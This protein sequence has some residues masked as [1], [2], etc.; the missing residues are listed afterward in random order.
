MASK[1]TNVHHRGM[2]T[3]KKAVLLANGKPPLKTKLEKHLKHADFFMCADGGANTAARMGF[4]PDLIIGDLDSISRSTLRS[5]SSVKTRRIA[6]QNSTDLEKALNWL[7]KKGYGSIEIFGATGC[8]IDHTIGNLSAAA[9]FRHQSSIILYDADGLLYPLISNF[10]IDLPIGNI[11]SLIPL[12][13]CEGVRTK[14]LRWNL[15][16]ESMSL[17]TREGTSNVVTSSP[18]SVSVRR[19]TLILFSQYDRSS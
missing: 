17:G 10:E 6:D 18:V 5:F 11:V 14:G 1:K 12:T 2:Q 13:L 16:Y 3:T 15:R 19:G 7:T 9:K 8:R 4:R